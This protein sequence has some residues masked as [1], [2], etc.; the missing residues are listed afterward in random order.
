[1][2]D[3]LSIAGLAASVVSLGIQAADGAHAYLSAIKARD[4][5]LASAKSQ[6]ALLLNIFS[7]LRTKI[8]ALGAEHD[9]SKPSTLD[10]L[11]TCEAD[12]KTLQDT[13][14]SLLRSTAPLSGLKDKVKLQT[15]R[16]TYPFNRQHIKDLE[17]R[18]AKANE[19][20]QLALHAVGM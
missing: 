4:E 15:R 16:L 17:T 7:I 6:T 1:M 11:T 20:L 19:S 8:S 9:L 2:A 5:E 18:L 13:V 10:C 14:D 12:L 3:P